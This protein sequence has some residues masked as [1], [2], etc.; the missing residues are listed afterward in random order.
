MLHFRQ[1]LV[2]AG[3]FP[4]GLGLFAASDIIRTIEEAQRI[5]HSDYVKCRPFELRGQVTAVNA[6][7]AFIL[8]DGSARVCLHRNE[9][10]PLKTK[11]VPG[12]IV[13]TRGIARFQDNIYDWLR[14]FECEVVGHRDVPPAMQTTLSRVRAGEHN[15][16]AVVVRGTITSAS[17]DEIDERWYY[18]TL[19]DNTSSVC[20]SLRRDATNDQHV[21]RL[22]GSRVQ[23]KG[24]ASNWFGLRRFINNGIHIDS[25][26]DILVLSPAPDPFSVPDLGNPI[27]L[28]ADEVFRLGRR[29]VSGR[30][31]AIWTGRRILLSADDGRTIC[32]DLALGCPTPRTGE[33]VCAAGLVTTDLFRLNLTDAVLMHRPEAVRSAQANDPTPL[34]ESTF[35]KNVSVPRNSAILFGSPVQLSGVIHHMYFQGEARTGLEVESDGRRFRVET[36]D[37]EILGK[38][39]CVGCRISATGLFVTESDSWHPSAVLPRI[40]GMA[41]VPRTKDDIRILARPPWWTPAR[42]ACA[43]AA[44]LAA[45]IG[46]FLWNRWLNRLVNR[47]SRE[48]FKEQIASANA[49]LRID[50]RTR[51]AAE[52]HDSLSQNLSG[53]ACQ[54]NAAKLTLEGNPETRDL[55]QTTERMLQSCRTEL[56]RCIWDLRGDTLE[57]PDFTAAIHKTLAALA[58]PAEIQIRFNVPRAKVSDSTAHAILCIVRELVTNAVRHG[59]ATCVKVAGSVERNSLLFSVRDD[60]RGFDTAN[61][62]GVGEGHFGLAG[63]GDRIS[64]LGGTFDLESHPG[65]GTSAR[66]AIPLVHGSDPGKSA[67]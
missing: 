65:A 56:T 47:R 21:A 43:M 54:L 30:V 28:T 27:I 8:S 45:L 57:E 6:D 18:L 33:S 25:T 31:L 49:E 29:K 41:I 24:M 44:M 4:A 64:R 14:V 61:R 17:P 36:G 20:L 67:L 50:E 5:P 46:F 60:G 9:K 39:L 66:I 2:L 23:V 1:I 53:I 48:L 26:K 35:L 62:P 52:L 51:L 7:H 63:I 55:L 38:D 11:P 42:L 16:Q 12:D 10:Q 59:H 13:V 22:V 32:V 37:P 3:I 34:P 40:T 19:Q 15:L 58:L